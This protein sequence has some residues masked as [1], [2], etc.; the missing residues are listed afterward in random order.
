MSPLYTTSV[1]PSAGHCT[2]SHQDHSVTFI[3]TIIRRRIGQP[4]VAAGRITLTN[5]S[6]VHHSPVTVYYCVVVCSTF[7]KSVRMYK[8]LSKQLVLCDLT[9]AYEVRENN[10]QVYTQRAISYIC[11]AALLLTFAR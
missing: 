10:L 8:S 2:K 6:R 11:I 7:R 9:R 3:V 1:N 4:S 5:D